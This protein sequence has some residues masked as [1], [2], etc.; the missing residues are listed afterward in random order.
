[1][2]FAGMAVCQTVNHEP[3]SDGSEGWPRATTELHVAEQMKQ[4]DFDV[5][6]HVPALSGR[7][8]VQY[9]PQK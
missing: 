4:N 1:M 7:I 3:V 8:K 5:L 6:C 9:I 2:I